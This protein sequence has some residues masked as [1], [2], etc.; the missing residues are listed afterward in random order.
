MTAISLADLTSKIL[1]AASSVRVWPTFMPILD[2]G[3]ALA[4]SE[5]TSGVVHLIRP[6]CTDLN[7]R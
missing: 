3:M 5:V 6:A 4:R 1:T 2:G 7:A